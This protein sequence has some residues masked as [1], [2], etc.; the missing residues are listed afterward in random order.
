M[1]SL[2]SS[3]FSNLIKLFL[4]TPVERAKA[5]RVKPRAFRCPLIL[6][7]KIAGNTLVLGSAGLSFI[8]KVSLRLLSASSLLTS[9]LRNYRSLNIS[10]LGDTFGLTRSSDIGIE[11][12]QL[13]ERGVSQDEIDF[14][15]TRLHYA[16][17]HS[18]LRTS[19]HAD[20]LPIKQDH[21]QQS[22][23]NPCFFKI[24]PAS[25]RSCHADDS[26]IR[27]PYEV[28]IRS[29]HT[30]EQVCLAIACLIRQEIPLL[31]I[32]GGTP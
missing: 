19:L 26:L 4:E 17:H 28:Y 1:L 23:R 3:P 8:V 32:I 9:S 5:S 21:Y 11:H 14:P 25:V 16:I 10:Y 18:S 24:T 31:K 30:A 6:S 27:F 7:Q 12:S 20:R 2:T 22:Y 13:N 15:E 29:R